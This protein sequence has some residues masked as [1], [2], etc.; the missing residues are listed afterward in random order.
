MATQKTKD[1]LGRLITKVKAI[2]TQVNKNTAAIKST[3]SKEYTYYERWV[4]AHGGTKTIILDAN[5]EYIS[6][7]I[8]ST[9]INYDYNAMLYR[10]GENSWTGNATNITRTADKK[11]WTVRSTNNE[12]YTSLTLFVRKEKV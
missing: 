11:Q 7:N 9:C 1:I 8:A 10:N 4:T 12:V 6:H 3:N 5:E 2:L